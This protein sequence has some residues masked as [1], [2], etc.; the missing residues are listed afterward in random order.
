MNYSAR[1]RH[2]PRRGCAWKSAI[3]SVEFLTPQ[4]L[5]RIT[6]KREVSAD[7][8]S[9]GP[10]VHAWD[11]RRSTGRWQAARPRLGRRLGEHRRSSQSGHKTVA[12][13]TS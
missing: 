4:R 3:E 5:S 6:S 12:T 10:P 13:L 2:L 7:L 1:C 11:W 9:D 8:R